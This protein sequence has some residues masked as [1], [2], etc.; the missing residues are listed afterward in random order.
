[1]A[2]YE[3]IPSDFYSLFVDLLYNF[4]GIR[5]QFLFLRGAN[6]VREEASSDSEKKDQAKIKMR[7]VNTLLKH[8]IYL[9]DES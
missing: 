7:I 6:E 5:N 4:Q 9:E 1:M 2:G 8:L 3:T